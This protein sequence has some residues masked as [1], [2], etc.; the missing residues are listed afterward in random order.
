MTPDI[1]G[2]TV[3]RTRA[4][5]ALQLVALLV[6]SLIAAQAMTFAVVVLMPPPVR[7][8]YRLEEVAQALKG[9][10][11]TA[12]Y[13]RPLVRTVQA[14]APAEPAPSHPGWPGPHD[15]SRRQL[16][17]LLG[18]PEVDVRLTEKPPLS[19]F[20]FRSGF[21]QRYDD[22]RGPGM[23]AGMQP[24][25]RPQGEGA[26]DSVAGL[27]G[28]GPPPGAGGPPNGEMMFAAPRPGGGYFVGG[29][30]RGGPDSRRGP[31][32]GFMIEGGRPLMG[33][34]TAAVRQS[35]GGWVVV[36]P[37]PDSFPNDW[38]LRLM[39]WLAG[40]LLLVVPLG[41][42]FARRIT[43]PIGKFARAAEALGRDPNAP[44]MALTG[45]AEIGQAARAFNDMQARLKRYV[46]D[47][48]AMMG[49]I[50]HD[51][52]TPLARIRFK[53]EAAS[54][55]L[56]QAVVADLEQME[57]MIASVLAF[58]RYASASR[59]RERLDLLSLLECLVDEA[60]EVGQEVGMGAVG[61]ATVEA[62]ALG[63][64]RLFRNLIDNAVKY[65]DRARVSLW[66]QGGEAVVEISDDGPGLPPGELE[67]VFEPFYRAESA[68]TLDGSGVGLGLAV[69]RS[70]ARAHGGDVSL[71]APPGQGLV[72]EVRLPLSKT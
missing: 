41:Y 26:G 54:D 28:P 47:R 33:A 49:A 45:P 69:A 3:G 51:L 70:L 12:R 27:A 67:R 60:V 15:W 36:R 14:A 66:R 7:E 43:A 42:L 9:G 16:A 6:V 52:R 68:R 2:D 23:Q 40:S 13:G 48:T 59:P 17:A 20:M 5:I 8:V 57:Q 46:D 55:P 61:P 38:Q 18:V 37:K 62:D 24:G 50:S 53:M 19:P 72:A 65:G 34:F 21:R 35:G 64:Q 58:I 11:L 10:A 63:L 31:R 56:K 29:E 71:S 22:R 4:P 32:G 1:G 25:P 44:M 30:G 39:L